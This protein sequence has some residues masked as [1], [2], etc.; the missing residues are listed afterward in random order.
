MRKSFLI[1]LL[2]AIVTFSVYL[3]VIHNGFIILDDWDYVVR[4]PNLTEGFS[5]P[6]IKW[7]FTSFYASNW[8]P[9]TWLSLILD[10]RLYGLNPA[11]Y[12]LTNVFIHIFATILL[13]ILF[14]KMTKQ[15]WQS[16]FLAAIFAIH[17]LHVESVAWV[18]E[19]KDVLSAF[20]CFLTLL[21]YF[22]YTEKRQKVWY[23]ITILAFSFGLMSKS[24]LV[25]VPIIMLL[26][27]IWPLDRLNS[28]KISFLIKE[29]IPFFA[30]SIIVSI[31][32]LYAQ[33]AGDAINNLKEASFLLRF[34]NSQLAYVQY[35]F[36]TVYPINLSVFYPMYL[37]PTWQAVL[38]FLL[39]F[40]VTV[41]V[42]LKRKKYPYLL[43]GW[44]WF[45]ITLIPVIGIVKVGAQ[46]MADRYSYIP[47]VGLLIIVAWGAADILKNI[48]YRK[49]I[50]SVLA[51]IVIISLAVL[52]WIQLGY[53]RD[54]VS[55]LRHAIKI[56]PYNG[57]LHYDMGTAYL[58][59]QNDLG[60]AAKELRLSIAFNP[61]F[62]D[63]H[64]NL[65]RIY[66]QLGD[67]DD[68]IEEARI[69]SVLDPKNQRLRNYLFSCIEL[70]K[71]LKGK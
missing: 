58:L 64:Y 7:A 20:F 18:A 17:P 19:R 32:T 61:Y 50:L 62:A 16:A 21:F 15:I 67:F 37:V 8:H 46:S 14:N 11:G 60:Q 66:M 12:H 4:N 56:A 29:K 35:I 54:S 68:G 39:L 53:W 69:A 71:A 49:W 22:S 23:F 59:E 57:M 31:I 52:S 42:I 24:M 3:R 5:L 70:R 10:Y 30:L 33:R 43:V 13:F 47:M 6:N 44:F 41:M 48:K 36:K 27:D 1:C 28:E 40:I 38:S 2:L 65:A 45:I 34:A 26:L 25:T 9:I 55:L 51:C 63:A